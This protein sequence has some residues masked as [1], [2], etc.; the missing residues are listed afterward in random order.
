MT[1]IKILENR[2]YKFVKKHLKGYEFVYITA[3]LRGFIKN[4][5]I[6]NPEQICQAFVR[7]LLKLNLTIIVPTYSYTDKGKFNVED[8]NSNLGFLT[9]W[10]LKQKIKRSEHPLFSVAALGNQI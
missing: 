5:S 3:D 8:E 6:E 4:Y 10:I 1:K 9:K 7:V 2:I